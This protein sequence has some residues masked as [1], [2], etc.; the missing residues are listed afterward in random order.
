MCHASSYRALEVE[1]DGVAVIG[2]RFA[3]AKVCEQAKAH[4]LGGAMRAAGADPA[5][6]GW[7]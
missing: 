3:R 7:A 6:D 1:Q 4:R 5:H 2:R